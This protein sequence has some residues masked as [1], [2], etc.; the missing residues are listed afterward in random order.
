MPNVLETDLVSVIIRFVSFGEFD[1]FVEIGR[2][3]D[4][5]GLKFRRRTES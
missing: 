3:E 4:R 1:V 5:T 2:S